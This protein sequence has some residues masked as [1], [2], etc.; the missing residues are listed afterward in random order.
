MPRTLIVGGCPRSGTTAMMRL[1]NGHPKVCLGDE[2]YYWRFERGEL[3]AG[4]FEPD[5]FFE[6]AEADRHWDEGREPLPGLTKEDYDAAAWR[7]DKYP[8]LWRA[9]DAIAERLPDARIVCVLRNPLSVAE[10]YA[11]RAEDGEDAWHFGPDRAL[12]DWNEAVRAAL[13]AVR[14][15]RDVV[16][17]TYEAVFAPGADHGPLFAALGLS[18]GPAWPA[19]EAVTAQAAAV[20]R[21]E[22]PRNETLRQAVCLRADFAAYRALA[23]HCLYA[24]S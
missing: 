19:S 20:F 10:S 17:A 23:A 21:R 8:P 13:A 2:R 16:V 12:D 4:L 22:E 18:A 6:L 9:Y 14:A 1:L 24:S 11:A 15:G 5:R 3:D 7:G